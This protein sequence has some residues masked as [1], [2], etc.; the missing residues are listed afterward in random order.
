MSDADQIADA[1][2]RARLSL[3]GLSVGDGFGQRFFIP[4]VAET[5]TRDD[6]PDG[7]WHYTDDTE[8]AMAIVQVLERYGEIDQD[9]LARQFADRY[10]GDS[11]RGYGAGA[12]K[13]LRQIADGSDWRV[14]SRD[15][16]GGQRSYGNGGAMRAGPLGA[17]FADDVE[18]AIE[19]ARRSAEVTHAHPEGQAGAIA[20]GLAAVWTWQWS[21]S[22]QKESPETMLP[23]V[24]ERMPKSTVTDR[25]AAVVECE[26]DAW[27]FDV[28]WEFGCG[29]QV[30]AEDTVPFCLWMAAAHLTDYCEAMW[31]TARVGGDVDTTCAI[32]G[33]IV[34]LSAGEESIPREWRRLREPLAW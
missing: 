11:G 9:V 10:V 1:S 27:A 23:W 21:A 34:A 28:A 19:N 25:V 14:A 5:A 3:T 30:C 4:W 33:S 24:V 31:T 22:G 2:Y 16:F 17:W 7:P 8:M 6:L 13:L 15:L 12:H 18:V 20:V 32:V 29:D 26:L